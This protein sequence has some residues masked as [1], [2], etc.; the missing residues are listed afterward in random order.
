MNNL[1][2]RIP[3]SHE[4]K[5]HGM[6]VSVTIARKGIKGNFAQRF[7]SYFAGFG[8]GLPIKAK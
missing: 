5:V 7:H 6:F 8:G 2:R 4:D 1:L 3:F